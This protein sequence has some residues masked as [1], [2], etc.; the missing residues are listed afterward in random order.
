MVLQ[1]ALVVADG[2]VTH[3]DVFEQYGAVT[4]WYHGAAVRLFGRTLLVVRTSSALLLASAIG[5]LFGAWR[6]CYGRGIAYAS[7]LLAIASSYFFTPGMDMRAWSSDTLIF[8][9]A[10]C[11]WL[12]CV[13][14]EHTLTYWFVGLLSGVA[15]FCRIGPGIAQIVL[16]AVV[17][18]FAQRMQLRRFVL[19][20][21]LGIVTIVG[22]FWITGA[23]D[24][25]WYQ[26]VVMPAGWVR[27]LQGSSPMHFAW[28]I[29]RLHMAPLIIGPIAFIWSMARC[30][31]Q[32]SR[33]WWI[34]MLV[35]G[36]IFAVQVSD[37]GE[38]AIIDRLTFPWLVLTLAGIGIIGVAKK[39]SA[40]G[41]KTSS[42]LLAITV[43]VASLS[44]IYPVVEA[45][46]LWWAA[47][48]ASGFALSVFRDVVSVR[49][50]RTAFTTL[51]VSCVSVGAL[52]DLHRNL[53]VDRVRVT[54]NDVLNGMYFDASYFK[55]FEN[56]LNSL[57]AYAKAHPRTPIINMCA[58]GLFQS[59]TGSPEMPDPYYVLWAFRSKDVS[60]EQRAEWAIARRPMAWFC[61]PS[62][63]E[64]AQAGLF[65]LRVIPLD[66]ATKALPRQK[67]WPFMSALAVPVEW[68][69]PEGA[70]G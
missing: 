58:D 11:I 53:S 23:V 24:A 32:T 54:N 8:V 42:S 55:Y 16:I 60:F 29:F 63:D 6:S 5:L 7:L 41:W 13:R 34:V 48:P 21:G 69:I 15:V 30:I 37:S 64:T 20:C 4:A 61:P 52:V 43:S 17:L 10:L 47:V 56:N 49:S 59:V 31:E 1:P 67:E 44:Q 27:D 66:S 22:Y 2:G 26:T 38:V 50:M 3:R 62:P 45:R 9:Q 68:P 18:L 33:L 70:T 36:M 12:F 65:G 19:G 28:S 39:W 40:L 57:A 35:S 46:H 14:G 25:W 51:V